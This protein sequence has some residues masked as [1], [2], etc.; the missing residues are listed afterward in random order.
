MESAQSLVK[1][2]AIG[3]MKGGV[4]KSTL[5]IQLSCELVARGHSTTLCD[6]DEQ[7]TSSDWLRRGNLSV[8]SVFTPIETAAQASLLIER[9]KSMKSDAVVIDLPPHTREA[10]EAAVMV[11]DLLLIPVT[12]SGADF[13]S[14]GKAL[15]LLREGRALRNGAPKALLV[16]SKVDRRTAFGREAPEA[17]KGFGEA[18][19]PVISQRSAHVDCFG[20][21]DWIGGAYP[22]SSAYEEIKALTDIVEEMIEWRAAT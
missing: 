8:E 2:I 19:G 5:A 3:N 15:A 18:V 17:L 10:T 9:I 12:P 20:L 7:G 4:G 6:A 16:P 21:A 22:R 13:T 1:C 14:T 11:C